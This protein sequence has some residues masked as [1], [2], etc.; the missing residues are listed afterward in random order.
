MSTVI[1]MDGMSGSGKSTL[2]RMLAER[3]QFVHFNTGDIYRGLTALLVSKETPIQ[4]GVSLLVKTDIDLSNGRLVID[5]VDVSDMLHIPQVEKL[6]AQV[7]PIPQVR[8]RVR[9][10]QYALADSAQGVVME[11]RDIAQLFPTAAL[12]FFIT[13][14]PQVRAERRFARNMAEHGTSEPLEELVEQLK[15]RDECDMNREHGRLVAADDA[16]QIDTSESDALTTMAEIIKQIEARTPELLTPAPNP[17]HT[18]SIS[19]PA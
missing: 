9:K 16:I 7:S 17:D 3:L 4:D 14:S 10:L 2:A 6:V 12:K 15:K 19:L 5:G 1:A 18:E 8:E 11:G 13:A